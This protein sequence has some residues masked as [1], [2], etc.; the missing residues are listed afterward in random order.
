MITMMLGFALVL[1]VRVHRYSE[2]TR[3]GP[4]V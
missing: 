1:S 2:V 3:G 4:F